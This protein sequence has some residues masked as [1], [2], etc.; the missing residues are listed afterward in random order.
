MQWCIVNPLDPRTYEQADAMLRSDKCAGLKFHPE[1][2]CYTIKEYGEELFKFG[3][4]R[5]ATILVHSGDRERQP[6]SLQPARDQRRM[7]AAAALLGHFCV[8]RQ[9]RQPTESLGRALGADGLSAVC[10]RALGGAAGA[11]APGELGGHAAGR[12]RRCVCRLPASRLVGL[13]VPLPLILLQNH[14]ASQVIL[15]TSF[16]PSPPAATATST[17]TRPPPHPSPRASSSD[18]RIVCFL[19]LWLG[20]ECFWNLTCVICGQVRGGAG[21]LRPDRVRDRHVSMFETLASSF[22][23]IKNTD[24]SVVARVAGRCTSRRCNARGWTTRTSRRRT[25][26]TSCATPRPGCS[27]S[28]RPLRACDGACI[29][30]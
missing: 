22:A 13:A 24:Q 8:R 12:G 1:E 15:P 25:A 20:S 16:A 26:R 10:G 3:A 17:S 14:H 7:N 30:L 11:G 18:R 4:A 21:G 2:H 19:E 9:T 29:C 28:S 23:F 6:N 5:G 27:G